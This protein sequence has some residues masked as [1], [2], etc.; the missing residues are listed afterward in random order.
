MSLLIIFG[1]C[2]DLSV[3]GTVFRVN[4]PLDAETAALG[5]GDEAIVL[6]LDQ[7]VA[8]LPG[9]TVSLR[10]IINGGRT[11]LAFDAP[12]D[13]LIRRIPRQPPVEGER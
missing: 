11:M 13:C 5:Q 2:Q 12:P 3:D 8:L 1:P 10:K 7:P 9:V 6:R 4:A